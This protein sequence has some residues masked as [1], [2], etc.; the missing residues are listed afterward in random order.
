MSAT[1][2]LSAPPAWEKEHLWLFLLALGFDPGKA[3]AGRVSTHICLGVNMF[4]KPNK[5]AFSIV[6][7]FL[8]SSVDQSHC[9][10]IFRFCFPLT[11]KKA[12]SEFRKHSYEWLRRISD[13]CGNSFP[14]VVASLFLSP[15]GSKFIHLMYCFARYVIMQHVKA[16]SA[17]AGIPYP[18]A[19]NSRPPDLNIAVAKYHVARSR[20]LHSLQKEDFLIEELQKK[21]QHFSKRI[22]DL[23]FENADLDK[24]LQKMEKGVNPSQNN[25]AERVGKVRC[26][27]T[28]ITETLTRLQKEIEVVDSVVKGHIDQYILDGTSVAINVPR[29]LLEK[30]EKD[31]HQFHVGNVYEEGKL[32][33][34]TVVHLLNKALEILM[35]ERW[36]IDKNALKLD[37][38]YMEGKTKYQNINL[39]GLKSLRQ[40]LNREDC[41]SI[42]QS[43]SKKQQ[44]WD[45]K[46]ENCLGQ[47]PFHLIKNPDHALDLLPAMSPLSFSP[48][49][50]E[51]YKSSVFCQYPASIPDSTKKKSFQKTEFEIAGKASRCQG[52]SA[53]VI[54]DRMAVPS[55][56]LATASENETWVSSEK[57]SVTETPKA[58]D[59]S[60]Y[61]LLRYKGRNSRPAKAVKKKQAD[62]FKT[63]S[64]VKRDD[65]LK[66]AQEQLA[67][68]MADVVVSNSP[69]STRGGGG[70]ELED[71]IGTLISDPFLPKKQIPR[72]PENLITEIRSSWKKAIQDEE[73][74]SVELNHTKAIKDIQEDRV[75]ASRNQVDSSM[76]CFMSSCMSDTAESPFLEAQSPFCFQQVVTGR[77]ELLTHQAAAGPVDEMFWKQGLT[78]TVPGKCETK[79]PELGL[80]KTE[81][82]S[83]LEDVPWNSIAAETLPPCVSQNSSMCTTV[84]WDGLPIGSG[85]DSREV[86]QLGILQES[87]P[88][89]GALISLNKSCKD[90]ELDEV[91]EDS[92]TLPDCV[93]GSECKLD[94]QSI[95]RRLE[96]LKKSVLENSLPSKKQIPRCRSEFSLSLASLEAHNVLTPSGKPYA[97]DAELARKPS[98][99]TPLERKILL[100][101]LSSLPSTPQR[102]QPGSQDRGDLLNEK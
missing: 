88:G 100:S 21:A 20:F 56:S 60:S 95:R 67:E 45:L 79:N 86:I 102:E 66:K 46:W 35:H 10:E 19:V 84:S 38:Q 26:L 29:P 5:D 36:R 65:P 34:L 61:Q 71:L 92:S 82:A 64:S 83:E 98:H 44:E 87:L 53:G 76:A 12:D 75:P 42:K 3:A 40:K 22:R 54:A 47:S 81:R 93:A 78:H 18:E 30:V 25:T 90:F 85:S 70:Q 48:A 17:G 6:V 57:G 31:M 91:R 11:D 41:V 9:N 14:P 32:N 74:S 7:H 4:D 37:L 58:A 89:E 23:K 59:H 62:T 27:W 101:P 72:T 77:S 99:T 55:S 8:F 80:L 97:S 2:Q 68:Q 28:H 39:Q 15:G 96:A 13:E 63:P 50:E 69:Q 94:L 52:S 51:A 24:Q 73:A 1:Q 43:I 49:T 16:D 33:V